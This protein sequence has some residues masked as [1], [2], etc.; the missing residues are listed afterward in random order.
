MILAEHAL[1]RSFGSEKST[2]NI[3]RF[4]DKGLQQ[5]HSGSEMSIS[6]G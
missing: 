3:I 6:G 1:R 2:P 4:L 5:G